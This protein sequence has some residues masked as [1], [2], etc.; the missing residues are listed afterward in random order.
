MEG[1][2]IGYLCA[3]VLGLILILCVAKIYTIMQ[4]LQG[5]IVLMQ[6]DLR[7]ITEQNS[8]DNK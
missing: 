7:K 2:I 4:E 3:A 6:K 8:S 5:T 1:A